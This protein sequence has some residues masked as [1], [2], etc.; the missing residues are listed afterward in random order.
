MNASLDGTITL[1]KRESEILEKAP[2]LA[3]QI[4]LH[5]PRISY[6]AEHIKVSCENILAAIEKP[7]TTN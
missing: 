2:L 7:P 6:D 3:A 1:T 4:A 5:R